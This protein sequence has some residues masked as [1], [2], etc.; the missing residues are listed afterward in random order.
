MST[1][2]ADEYE[3]E[4]EKV[5]LNLRTIF[6]QINPDIPLQLLLNLENA[7]KTYGKD[8]KPYQIVKVIIDKFK[9]DHQRS[10]SSNLPSFTNL[11][12]RPKK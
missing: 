11:A 5:L 2:M 12:I 4:L 6:V 1:K 10:V 3:Q 8:S 9:E 7:E